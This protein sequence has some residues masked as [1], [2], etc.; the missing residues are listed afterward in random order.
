MKI[1]NDEDIVETCNKILENLD[2][3][4]VLLTLGEGGIAVYEKNKNLKRMPTKARKVADV[5]GAGDTVISTLTMA[6][7][8][9]A[10]IY[11]ASFL[12]NYAGGIVCEEVGIIPIEI[13]KL[14]DTII[15]EQKKNSSKSTD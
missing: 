3:K 4:Y 9:G 10:D 7:A 12:A 13:D 5:S 1:R 6:L 14:F 8:S 11:E 2:A 15:S